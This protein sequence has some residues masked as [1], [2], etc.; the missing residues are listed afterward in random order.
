[1]SRAIAPLSDAACR[2]AKRVYKLFD[3]DGLYLLI[4]LNDRNP[5][6]AVCMPRRLP[7]RAASKWLV[8]PFH[9]RRSRAFFSGI[10]RAGHRKLHCFSATASATLLTDRDGLAATIAMHDQ[11]SVYSAICV[12]NLSS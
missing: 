10:A 1:M 11:I 12:S 2:S 8:D 3:G 9:S 4:Q 6:P 7:F 5:R